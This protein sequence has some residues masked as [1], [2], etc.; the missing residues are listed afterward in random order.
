MIKSFLSNRLPPNT[1]SLFL[2]SIYFLAEWETPFADFLNNEDNFQV[3]PTTSVNTTFMMGN[4]LDIPFTETKDY[5]LVCLPYKNREVGMYIIS[6]NINHEHKYNIKKFAESINPQEIL[7]SLN[8]MKPHDVTV[9]I[10]K[11]SL[12]NSLSIL[13]PLQ[14]YT[15][16]EKVNRPKQQNTNSIDDIVNKVQDFKNFTVPMHED[17]YLENASKD[18]PLRVSDIIQQMVFSINEKGTEAAAVS[19]GITDY[20]GG[21][22][23]L[24]L[25]RPFSFFIR[26]EETQAV[27]FWGTI[28]NP[29]KN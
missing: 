27:I 25:N 24:I 5:R 18:T 9:K 23:T 11:L 29:T 4:I 26:H 19:G 8:N 7:K 12:S 21:A 20:M 13:K 16:F 28:S 14:R 15:V 2:N 6:P 22:K 10:P 17:I 3:N 1:A